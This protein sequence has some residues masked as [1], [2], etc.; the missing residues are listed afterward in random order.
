MRRLFFYIIFFS[1][2]CYVNGLFGR[3]KD[4]NNFPKNNILLKSF[5][6]KAPDVMISWIGAGYLTKY[7]ISNT[8]QS[9][10]FEPP[11]GWSFYNGL[12]PTGYGLG[13]G[14]TG[15][16][17]RGT[18]QF[19]VWAAGLWVG[20][21]SEHFNTA[22]DKSVTVLINGKRRTFSNVRVAAC[23]Y[24]S[25]LSAISRLWQSNQLINGETD[26]KNAVYKGKYLFGQKDKNIEDYQDVWAFFTPKEGDYYGM[27]EKDTIFRLDYVEINKKRI[28]VLES[29]PSL[30]PD[31]I[32]LDP[33][34]FDR[35]GNII[36][37]IVS[38]ED[39]YTVF[40]DYIN[41]KY[42][43]FLWTMGYDLRPV[44]IQVVQRTYSWNMDDFIYINYKIKNM[45]PFPL[46]SVF[47]GYFMDND[48]GYADDDMIGFDKNLNIGYSYDYDLIESGWQSSAGY[49]GT[50]F[51][52][53]PTDTINGEEKEIGLTGFHTWIRSDLGVSEGFP[54]DVDDEGTDHLKY[55]ELAMVDS[56]ETYEN[57]QDV[58]QLACSGPIKRLEPGEEVS[59]TIAIVAG[60]SLSELKSNAELAVRKYK[61]G[62]I[63]PEPPPS[64]SLTAIPGHHKVYLSWGKEPLNAIDPYTGEADFEGFRVNRS[65]TGLQDDWELLKE[66]DIA[67][68]STENM[69]T[70]EYTK[71][72]SNVIATYEGLIGRKDLQSLEPGEQSDEE[73]QSLLY[74]RFKEAIYT[75]EFVKTQI[76]VDGVNKDTLKMIIYDVTN[77]QL[78]PF[79]Y[80]ALSNGY[81]FCI[82][83][84]YNGNKVTGKQPDDIYRS[85][86]YIYF[87]GIFIK[88]SNGFYTDRDGD[89]AGNGKWD[90]GE[91]FEDLNGNGKYDTGEPF[92][93]VEEDEKQLQYLS[94]REGDIFTV[95]TF[96]AKDIGS[97]TDLEFTY[98]DEGLVNGMTYYYCVTSFDRGYPHL[99][100]PSI[101]SSYY[102]NMIAVVPQHQPLNYV[103][104][105]GIS[106]VTHIGKSTGRLIVN[107]TDS[108][109]LKGHRYRV[110]FF[111]NNPESN[112]VSAD[113]GIIIDDDLPYYMVSNEIVGKGGN[114][115]IFTGKISNTAIVPGSVV[116]KYAGSEIRD[117]S[118]GFLYGI[119]GNDT[120]TG[121]VHY[122]N[123][124]LK[125]VCKNSI[126]S[127]DSDFK[128]T[129]AYT[130]LRLKEWQADSLTS[131]IKYNTPVYIVG[132]L[133]EDSTFDEHGFIFKVESPKLSI[134]SLTWSLS[135]DQSDIYRIKVGSISK[136]EPYDY[137]VTFPDTGTRSAIATLENSPVPDQRVPWK[138]YNVTLGLE[139]RSFNPNGAF[140]YNELIKWRYDHTP[141]YDS[142]NINT[143][144]VLP[145]YLRGE[146]R[147]DPF[148]FEL[149]LVPVDTNLAGAIYLDPPS[150]NDT[151]YVFTS[152]PITSDDI[153]LFS[154]YNMFTE[155]EDIDM[156]KIKVV[157]NPYY[158]RAAWDRDRYNQHIDFRHLPE[159]T[160]D[161]PVHVRIFNL[162]G[163][164]V[165]HLKKN[166]VIDKNEVRDEYGT[167]S[168]D[169][170]DFNGLKIAS[171]LYIYQ[172]EARI[173]GKD[174]AKVG[175]IAIVMGP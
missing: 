12:W 45:N 47:V 112:S 71:G 106:E 134:D 18:N 132:E 78:V 17:P 153:F 6:L 160:L 89:N 73:L 137:I 65:I 57:P 127:S 85:C 84:N 168:W 33:F 77:R 36:G 174:Y 175:K 1:I 172:V 25:D 40:G 148:A 114:S 67:G 108:R 102:Q 69:A 152:K 38:D 30:D 61:T 7:T 164:L 86:Y 101:E 26:G 115:N 156:N 10:L 116:I 99:N 16:F 24:Y 94:P 39:T 97:Q 144:R 133:K 2:I 3:L 159:G 64:P 79:N 145:E 141:P 119:V 82:Y 92:I 105:P 66:Y 154:T 29:N 109:K 5:L 111:R 83:S 68:D 143:I 63:G 147:V 95:R 34:R 142:L 80:N 31:L 4:I 103:G 90:N 28:K 21:K 151:L 163:A 20:A 49:I 162:A 120:V 35:N 46:D 146:N 93:D 52:E 158:I 91:Y 128:V 23:A 167:L 169:L 124:S 88:I 59:V 53:T 126:F 15:E 131:L 27:K 56:F 140:I 54:G 19:Y 81:G 129:Y 22:D 70:I 75:I 100:I 135:T 62:F 55:V 87:D 9:G 166:G 122:G 173:N 104:E 136:I 113:Y 110:L 44:G 74:K 51:V 165:A 58:R 42:G 8:G 171:G 50:I 161:N 123:G 155:V 138:V 32:L 107:V 14:R 37:D 60:A 139:S 48:I 118:S 121:S 125:L 72:S 11:P 170:R 130:T 98:V 96:R 117:D 150:E 76:I 41:E 149:I 157:P 13:N 43:S